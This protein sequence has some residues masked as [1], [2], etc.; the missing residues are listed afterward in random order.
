M[1]IAARRY[2]GSKKMH[3]VALI[4]LTLAVKGLLLDDPFLFD[5]YTLLKTVSAQDLTIQT[6]VFKVYELAKPGQVS[7]WNGWWAN[8]DLKVNYFRPVAGIL[9]WLEYHIWGRSPFMFHLDSM[10]AYLGCVVILH[11]LAVL[12]FGTWPGLLAAAVFAA[13]PIHITSIQWIANRVDALSCLGLSLGFLIYAQGLAGSIPRIRALVLMMGCFGF[14]LLT[15]ENASLFPLMLGGFHFLARSVSA[16]TTPKSGW[17]KSDRRYLGVS[18]WG[19]SAILLPWLVGYHLM[20]YGVAEGYLFIDEIPLSQAVVAMGKSLALYLGHLLFYV[21]IS[22]IVKLRLGADLLPYTVILTA[23]ALLIG[24]GMLRLLKAPGVWLTILLVLSLVPALPFWVNERLGFFSVLW[25]ALLLGGVTAALNRGQLRRR[26]KT[27]IILILLGWT[28]GTAGA[29][30]LAT[31]IKRE[32]WNRNYQG[33][34]IEQSRTLLERYPEARELYFV[35]LPDPLLAMALQ[36]NLTWNLARPGLV[37]YP[38]FFLPEPPM[39]KVQAEDQL[40]L[41][42]R[43]AGRLEAAAQKVFQ[44][45]TGL[46]QGLTYELDHFKAEVLVYN[47]VRGLEL[48]LTFPLPLTSDRYL[49]IVWEGTPMR[50]RRWSM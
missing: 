12:L 48:E 3:T 21:E 22:E 29:L 46:K 35:N 1:T 23:T 45:K 32:T 6:L 38:L 40:R 41:V 28:V 24:Y 43:Q 9:L 30:S 17:L 8:P 2:L 10:I 27:G 11:R 33:V 26:A 49:F 31:T 39:L 44:F 20:D 13:S 37:A 42:S 36:D 18:I 7:H 16:A 34:L 5:D 25:Y 15:K 19:C 47:K 14:A 4:I 50:A